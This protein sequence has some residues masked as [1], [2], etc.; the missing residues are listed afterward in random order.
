MFDELSCGVSLLF[1]LLMELIFI[2]YMFGIDKLDILLEMQT[3][4]RIPK[5]VKWICMTFIP[6]FTSLMIVL[7][8]IGE[9]SAEKAAAR[10]W[11]WWVTTLGRM[12]F[13]I[14]MCIGLFLGSI[15]KYPAQ[16]SIYVLI[17]K[18]YGI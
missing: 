15:K 8:L 6:V 3:G 7:N 17:E 12:L 16:V 13:I 1:C 11:D 2:G 5:I 14:P 9:F 4:E 10:N 18:Q